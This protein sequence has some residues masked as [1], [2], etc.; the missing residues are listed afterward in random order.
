L[1]G[2]AVLSEGRQTTYL[3]DGLSISIRAPTPI[4]EMRDYYSNALS[5]LGWDQAPSRAVPGA[6]MAGVQATRDDIT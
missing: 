4:A 6:P 2:G 3:A 1:P 5:D